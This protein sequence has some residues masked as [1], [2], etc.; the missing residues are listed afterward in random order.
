LAPPARQVARQHHRV[1]A[2]GAASCRLIQR[3]YLGAVHRSGAS[4]FNGDRDHDED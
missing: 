4:L 3:V 1:A 2:R